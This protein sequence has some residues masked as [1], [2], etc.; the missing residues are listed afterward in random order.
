[1]IQIPYTFITDDYSFKS[2]LLTLESKVGIW[3]DRPNSKETIKLTDLVKL[4]DIISYF[5]NIVF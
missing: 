3:N 2:K 5:E 4:L 1:M